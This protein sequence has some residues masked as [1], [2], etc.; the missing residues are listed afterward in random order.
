M[1]LLRHDAREGVPADAHP[2][3]EKC[4]ELEHMRGKARKAS[5]FL[6]AVAHEN[7][8]LMLC[9][10]AER[11]HAVTELEQA[12]ELSQPAISQQLAR[13]RLDGIVEARRDGRAIHYRLAD[14]ATRNFIKAIYDK[15]WPRL[16]KNG[17][18]AAGRGLKPAGAP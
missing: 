1:E 12:L 3:V 6:K 11:E 9:L 16:R 15:F 13:S 10:L 4:S 2:S 8:L 17:L 5:A 14:E 7:R 18:D